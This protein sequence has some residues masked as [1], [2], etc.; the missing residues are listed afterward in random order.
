MQ[1]L[2]RVQRRDRR[3][4]EVRVAAHVALDLRAQLVRHRRRRGIRH[5]RRG[6]RQVDRVVPAGHAAAVLEAADAGRV[7][8]HQLTPVDAAEHGVEH[9]ERRDE[10]GD[11]EVAD[12]RAERLQ[13]HERGVAHVHARR[14]GG[15]VRAQEHAHLAARRLDRVVDLARRHA[16][17]LGDELEVVDQRLHARRELVSRR[18]RVLAVGGDVRALGEAVERLVDDPAALLDLEDAHDHPVPVVADRA[19]RDLEVEVLV[20]ASTA[21]PCAGPR[22]CRR[23]AAAGRSRRAR[24]ASRRRAARRP[25]AAAARSRSSSGSRGT[26]RRARACRARTCAPSA[27]SR[28]GCPRRRRRPGSSACAC[29]GPRTSRTGRGSPRGRGSSTRTSRSRRGPAR[30]CRARRGAT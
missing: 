28:S 5:D 26:G 29:A 30:S 25:A 17:A 21:P 10:V 20:G 1:P 3:R 8:R 13:V 22:G 18:Q 9:P 23:R 27:P 4:A 2:R 14:L 19:D 24:A 6:L 7:D 15:A 12:H 16:E 11:V